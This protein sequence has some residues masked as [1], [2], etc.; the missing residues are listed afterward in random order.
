MENNLDV[1]QWA[2]NVLNFKDDDTIHPVPRARRFTILLIEA[3]EKPKELEVIRRS[4]IT[5]MH[6]LIEDD[7]ILVS[8]L[9][10]RMLFKKRYD[11]L[12]SEILTLMSER[13][14]KSA[15]IFSRIHRNQLIIY[16]AYNLFMQAKHP[17]ATLKLS[18]FNPLFIDL[19]WR[20]SIMSDF[21][22]IAGMINDGDKCNI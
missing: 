12:L 10:C 13:D 17:E 15:D 5:F 18:K 14:G 16:Q 3:K 9:F 19:F 21:E 6:S 22:E 1:S 7:K 11:D 2:I 4:V 8:I 20:N